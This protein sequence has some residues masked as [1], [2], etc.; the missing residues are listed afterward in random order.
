M[1]SIIT[2]KTHKM[3]KVNKE[4]N[5]ILPFMKPHWDSFR[6]LLQS[7]PTGG[8]QKCWEEEMTPWDLGFTTPIIQHLVQTDAFPKG[9]R[10]LVPG[11]GSG[12]DVIAMAS[13]DRYVVGLE[14]SEVA[15]SK[16]RE[17]A[18]S[19]T[20]VNNM[21]FI[22]DDFFTWKS[23]ALF[24]IIF[25]YTFFCALEPNMRLAWASRMA[26]LLNPDGELLT[27]IFPISDHVGG[28]PYKVSVS[29][30]EEVLAPF[31]FKA[32]SVTEN[33]L[34]VQPRKGYEKLGRWKRTPNL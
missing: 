10:V 8:W 11:C 32:A 23:D 18:A 22:L 24:D 28:P 27:L 26:E 5:E 30:Y 13:S 14:L 2:E 9:N 21:T 34:A 12:Y 7:Q 20:N 25:D 3:E 1:S 6:Q 29:D 17:L 4:S 16:A 19:S 33:E 15:I 31:G